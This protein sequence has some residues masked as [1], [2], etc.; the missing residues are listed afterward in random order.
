MA[1]ALSDT[2]SVFSTESSD[3]YISRQDMLDLIPL[4]KSDM[5]GPL[6][7]PPYFLASNQALEPSQNNSRV[8]FDEEAK[9]EDPN[10]PQFHIENTKFTMASPAV[11]TA[12]S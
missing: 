10:G 12:M 7:S 8:S 4:K 6:P 9:L 3:D 2:E 11:S 5:S 1:S